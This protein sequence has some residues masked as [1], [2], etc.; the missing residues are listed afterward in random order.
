MIE[1]IDFTDT[2]INASARALYGWIRHWWWPQSYER[3]GRRKVVRCRAL[4]MA[5]LGAAKVARYREEHACSDAAG[6]NAKS[7]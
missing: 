2:E 3:A 1:A 5:S 6:D 4:A 7:S